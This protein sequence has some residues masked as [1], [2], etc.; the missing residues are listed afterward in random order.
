MSDTICIAGVL[1]LTFLNISDES[2]LTTEIQEKSNS[3]SKTFNMSQQDSASALF[4]NKYDGSS[5]IIVRKSSPSRRTSQENGTIKAIRL[6]NNGLK[7][8][9]ILVNPFLN[10]LNGSLIQWLDLSFN[11]IS[12]IC[13]ICSMSPTT[14][15][16]TTIYLHANKIS[17]L[18]DVKELSS[19]QKLKSLTL[20]GNAVEERKHYK[21]YCLYHNPQLTHFDSSPITKL[22][23]KQV[24][25]QQ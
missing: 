19:F 2:T 10:T 18:S 16:L 9:T 4:K 25:R 3:L 23:K 21:N 20:Y 12:S 13:S 1:D 6:S 7:D 17:K 5:D 22:D 15:N 24:Q 14:P 8:I 11:E